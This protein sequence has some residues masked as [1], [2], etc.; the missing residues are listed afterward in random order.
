[1][2]DIGTPVKISISRSLEERRRDSARVRKSWKVRK[3]RFLR[4]LKSN[5]LRDQRIGGLDEFK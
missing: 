1:M 4:G 2:F 5:G 3:K